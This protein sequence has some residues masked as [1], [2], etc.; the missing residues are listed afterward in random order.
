MTHIIL[1]VYFAHQYGTL[2]RTQAQ[3]LEAKQAGNP[4]D[5]KSWR[6]SWRRGQNFVLV[7]VL[8]LEDLSSALALSIV[9]VLELFIWAL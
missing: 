1:S 9:H 6:T 2:T 4:S 8:V 7:L 3:E 5:V